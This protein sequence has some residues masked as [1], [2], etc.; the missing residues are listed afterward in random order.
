MALFSVADDDATD[1]RREI[2]GWVDLVAV[3]DG[4]LAWTVGDRLWVQAVGDEPVQVSD[5]ACDS[6]VVDVVAGRVSSM[7]VC[8]DQ[9][10]A[11][12]HELAGQPLLELPLDAGEAPPIL[13]EDRLVAPSAEAVYVWSFDD[14]RLL[15][16]PEKAPV[17]ESRS[18]AR[19]DHLMVSRPGTVRLLHLLG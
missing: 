8:G 6:A 19:G 18:A 9:T 16:L 1:V 15:R 3:G 17:G 13:T 2:D 10:S 11:R 4:G 12:V 7:A 14:Q 5:G